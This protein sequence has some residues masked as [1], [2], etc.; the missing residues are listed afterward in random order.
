MFMEF[1]R[2]HYRYELGDACKQQVCMKRFF[3]LGLTPGNTKAVLE[4]VD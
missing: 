1:V 3:I 4:M 2:H